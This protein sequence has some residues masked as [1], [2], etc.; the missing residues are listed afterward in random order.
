M[1]NV[2]NVT[3]VSV[4]SC[5]CVWAGD[6]LL[7]QGAKGDLEL[8]VLSWRRR[9]RPWGTYLKSMEVGEGEELE[10]TAVIAEYYFADN[11]KIRPRCQI[12]W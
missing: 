6:P 1:N 11:P 4:W 7:A 12:L 8:L 2:T 10:P 5:M 3:V 9:R